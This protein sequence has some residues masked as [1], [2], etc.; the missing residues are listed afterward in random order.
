MNNLSK[1]NKQEYDLMET[2]EKMGSEIACYEN[3]G[4]I[5]KFSK[6]GRLVT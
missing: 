6:I 1:E 2:S 4:W 3:N 5:Q